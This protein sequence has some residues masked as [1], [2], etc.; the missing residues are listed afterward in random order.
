MTKRENSCKIAGLV[1]HI[2]IGGLMIFTRLMGAAVE[3]LRERTRQ[4]LQTI[5]SDVATNNFNQL[6]ANLEEARGTGFFAA[7]VYPSA[8]AG[9]FY[10]RLLPPGTVHLATSFNAI[11]WLDRLPPVPLTVRRT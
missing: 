9:S 6:F 8:I 1:L 11:Q 2:L 4:P 10:G 5:Y 3:G 7:G